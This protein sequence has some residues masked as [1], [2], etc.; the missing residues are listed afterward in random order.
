MDD[1]D[2]TRLASRSEKDAGSVWEDS[3]VAASGPS[4]SKAFGKIRL[5]VEGD[6]GK[7]GEGEGVR[8]KRLED[9]GVFLVGEKDLGAPSTGRGSDIEEVIALGS[10]V[11]RS[12]VEEMEPESDDTA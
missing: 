6:G 12:C 10:A 5:T 9:F 2:R 1:S 3:G 11:K 8:P 7:E 4:G